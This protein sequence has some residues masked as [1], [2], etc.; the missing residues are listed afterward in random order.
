MNNDWILKERH[1]INTYLAKGPIVQIIKDLSLAAR[2]ATKQEAE[3]YAK[4]IHTYSFTAVQIK[5]GTN[6]F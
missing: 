5:E 4:H 6:G 3:T 1:G 2:F